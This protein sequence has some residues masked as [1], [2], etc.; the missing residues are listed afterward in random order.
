MEIIQDK[1]LEED[2]LEVLL[3]AIEEEKA[4]QARYQGALEL[5]KSPESQAL[6]QDLVEV[7]RE[8]ERLLQER[9][10]QIKKKLEVKIIGKWNRWMKAEAG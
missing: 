1:L 10:D 8:H 3:T 6:F 2:L 4:A 7:E 9:Y 5:A